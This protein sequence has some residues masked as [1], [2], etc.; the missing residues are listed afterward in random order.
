MKK[1]FLKYSVIIL[2][3][4]AFFTSN[5]SLA[6]TSEY[7]IESYNIDMV[8]NENN[9]F[10]ITERINVNF[11]VAK[12]GIYRKIPLKNIVRRSDGTS[13][14][15]NVEITNIDVNEKYTVSRDGMYRIIKIGDKSRT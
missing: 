1:I 9:T 15:N 11:N 4:L 14:I 8:V 12:H 7:T 6:S 10:D 3:L 13:S 2:I 5:K